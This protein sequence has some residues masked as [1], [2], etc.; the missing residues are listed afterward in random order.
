MRGAGT[1]ATKLFDEFHPWVNFEQLLAKCFIGPLKTAT[2]DFN[3]FEVPGKKSS[4][5][6]PSKLLPPCKEENEE[7]SSVKVLPRFDWIQTTKN[8]TIYFYT[9]SLCNPGVTLTQIDDKNH[10]MEI[11]IGRYLHKYKFSFI[12]PLLFPPK[13]LVV[14]QESGK[15]EIVFEK[16]E[17]EVWN[18]FGIFEKIQTLQSSDVDYA[19]LT[20]CDVPKT[21]LISHDS[22]EFTIR[23]K[24]EKVILLPIGYH[25]SF[26]YLGFIRNYT[27][28][29]YTFLNDATSFLYDLNFLIKKYE[30]GSLSRHLAEFKNEELFEISHQK[31]SFDL[32]LLKD[33]RKLLLLAAG[34]GITPFLRLILYLLECKKVESIILLYFNKTSK[35]IWC[36]R[37][38]DEIS[39]ENERFKVKYILSEPEDGWTGLRGKVRKDFIEEI[40]QDFSF[41]LVCGPKGFNSASVTILNELNVENV[42]CFDG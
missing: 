14:H 18:N 34:S 24:M 30:Q 29:P 8:L 15:I 36:R 31:G 37:K 4:N 38:F 20:E 42:Y 35:D 40:I 2:L 16:L 6:S 22:I 10:Q 26:K 19:S 28:I 23:P 17:N 1:D 27:P 32:S 7:N 5:S 33:H 39:D 25:V 41:A 12:K 3:P 11:F 13:S 21:S 9:K